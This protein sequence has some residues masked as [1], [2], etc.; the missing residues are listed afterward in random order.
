MNNK[1]PE[2]LEIMVNLVKGIYGDDLNAKL[3]AEYVS[4]EFSVE[5]SEQDINNL[6]L[7]IIEQEKLD[8]ELTFKNLGL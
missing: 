5:V 1:L 4:N 3:V 7:E 8:T 2:T 6:Y